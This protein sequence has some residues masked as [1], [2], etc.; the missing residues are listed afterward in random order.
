MDKLVAVDAL[1]IGMYVKLQD[2][3]IK[4][5][6][7]EKAF[8]ITDP[9]QLR[10][11]RGLSLRYGKVYVD[12]DRQWQPSPIDDMSHAAESEKRETSV[13][14]P[15][16]SPEQAQQNSVDR[17]KQ[18][19]SDPSMEPKKKAAAVYQSAREIM[20]TLFE[21]PTAEFIKDTKEAV[22][23]L[24]D[25]VLEDEEAANALIKVTQHDYYTYTHSVNVGTLSICLAKKLFQTD[26]ASHDMR[27]LG[28]GFFLHDL[29]KVRVEKE[30]LNKPSRLTEAEMKR[31]RIHPYQSYKILQESSQ[32]SEECRVIAMQHHERDDGTGYPLRLKGE[33]IH[34]Y[35]RICCIADVYD[36]LT[37]KRSYKEAMPPFEALKIMKNEMLHHFHREIFNNFVMLFSK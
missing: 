28:A 3:S 32:L 5:T 14:E 12:L 31:M 2:D 10:Q 6:G 8:F 22:G 34:V 16:S 4:G 33:Q 7:L 11:I 1:Q 24:V 37:A 20:Q 13:V 18:A 27:E 19:A 30:I 29:G 17:I 36:A 35:G 26:T 9:G 23:S 15:E 25:M 21:C